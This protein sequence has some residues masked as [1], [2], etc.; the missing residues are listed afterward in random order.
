ME[1]TGDV[2]RLRELVRSARQQ[3]CRIGCVPTMGALHEGHLS[4]MRECRK[5]VGYTVVW[6]FVNPTQFGP[7]ED[8]DK[9]PRPLEADL[10]ACRAEQVDCV[11]TPDVATVYPP[12]AQTWVT[13]EELSKV[14]E[15]E[16]RPHHFR[17]VTTIVAK[18]FNLILPDVAVFGA[19]DYQQQLLI[20][21]MVRDL[22]FPIE[23]ITAPTVREADGLALSS[24]NA[25][26][27][28]DER[29]AALAL[30]RGLSLAEEAWK[31]GEDVAAVEQMLQTFLTNSPGVQ[32]Q[33][34]VIRNPETL[35]PITGRPASAVVLLAAYVGQTRL[36]DN[37]MIHS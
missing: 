2:A 28:A 13:V 30:S 26:L 9:Y 1:V 32:L 20:R 14:L 25:Y 24:R 16:H 22:D 37:R 35:Q 7:G 18:L 19:K 10:A 36:I 23:I 4:L 6:I 27:S 34:G 33:Y 15:G 5:H 3:G 11:F 21:Q 31:R 8:L 12:G 29:Q 17:G